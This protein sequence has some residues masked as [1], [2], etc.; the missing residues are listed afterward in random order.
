[1]AVGDWDATAGNNLTVGG[2]SIAEGW[3]PS[4]VNNSVRGL[5]AEVAT[6]RDIIQWSQDSWAGTGGGTVDVITATLDPAPTAY[7]TGMAVWLITAGANTGAVTLNLNSLGAKAVQKDGSALSG[8]EWGTGNL[9]LLV[10]DG[11]QF[12]VVYNSSG[13]LSNVVEDTTPQLGG[14]LDV[15]GNAIGDGTN[16]LL[17]FTEDAS[18][19]NHV[20][21]E[22]EA[23]GAGPIISSTGD[24]TNVDLD[25]ATKGSGVINLEATVT[26]VDDI[27]HAGDT[28]NK[29][30]FGTD[31]QDFQTGGSSRIDLSDSGV[32]LGGANARVTTVLDEDTM[33]SDSATALATQQS[34]KAYVDA[35]GGAATAW[36]LISNGTISAS[37]STV[38]INS[39]IDS[40]YD[41]YKIVYEDV[42]ISADAHI[43]AR[44]ES[45]GSWKA[46]AS[47][48][49]WHCATRFGNSTTVNYWDNLDSEIHLLN[50]STFKHDATPIGDSPLRIEINLVR[51]SD[52]ATPVA[53]DG[54]SWWSYNSSYL[55][56][57]VF[58]G[59]YLSNAAIT[60][61]RLLLDAGTLDGGTY[62]LYGASDGT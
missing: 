17:T 21:I 35:N 61:V 48:Y 28:N 54:I 4:A 53:V 34:I 9:L 10:Y 30:A 3:A 44:L 13:G 41:Y 20:N 42:I 36:T 52:S 6:W 38:D 1:M 12:Q 15:N 2:V 33:S 7:A 56:Y 58:Q 51:P 22:N 31:T 62:Y 27:Q 19:V 45:G 59:N 26:V 18:A 32:R 43:Y 57:S 37:S 55:C 40:T 60:G 8:A 5:M 11:T 50:G 16:E 47:D 46:G 25:I 24:D 14:Q 49:Q 29:V 23:T 39:G